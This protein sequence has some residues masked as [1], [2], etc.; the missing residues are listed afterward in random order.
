M[1]YYMLRKFIEVLQIS[2]NLA[3]IKSSQNLTRV[4]LV[5]VKGRK[6]GQPCKEKFYN[7]VESRKELLN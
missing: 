5:G 4:G 7:K 2:E 6:G 1:F 3:N